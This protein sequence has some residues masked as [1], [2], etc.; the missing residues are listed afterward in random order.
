MET[1]LEHDQRSGRGRR[2]VET[3]VH[4]LNVAHVSTG[5]AFELVLK[6][7]ATSEGRSVLNKHEAEKNY[8]NLGKKIRRESKSRGRDHTKYHWGF[9]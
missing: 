2:G 1:A 7:L 4:Y 3:N 6:A 8:R 5:L 9:S